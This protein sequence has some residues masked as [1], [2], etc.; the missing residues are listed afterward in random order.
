[1]WNGPWGSGLKLH[2][3]GYLFGSDGSLSSRGSDGD[4][5]SSTQYGA[6][7]GWY[8]YFNSSSSYMVDY[9]KSYGFSARCV[10]DY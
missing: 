6:A 4:Y 9:G 3:A 2:A 7:N 8:L 10:R 1:N 5:W